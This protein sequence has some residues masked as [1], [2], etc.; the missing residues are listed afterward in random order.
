MTKSKPIIYY[1]PLSNV[2]PQEIEWFWCPFM[3][4]GSVTILEG[5]PG[6]GK[7]FLAMYLAA[8]VST[9]G[10][11]PGG[12]KVRRG[13][14]LYL[15]AEDDPAY[16]IRPRIDAMAGDAERIRIQAD[17]AALDDIGL[18][19][20]GKEVRMHRP[21]LIIIDPLYA[22]VPSGADI[23]RPNEIRAFL[24]QLTKL[25]EETGAAI[26]VIRHLRKAKG[27]KALY[28]GAG[29]I[30]VIGVAR[31]ALMVG[32]HPDDPERRVVVHHKHNLS[33]RGESLAFRLP[34][35]PDLRLPRLVWDGK[36]DL[37]ADDL[38]NGGSETTS[39]ELVKGFLKEALKRGPKAAE[40]ILQRAKAEGHASRTLDR[41]KKA[42]GVQVRKNGKIWEWALPIRER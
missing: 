42:L 27:E 16:T 30:D 37:D 19:R 41:A 34:V 15:A 11:L 25:A 24:V 29:S 35:S 6:L 31:S 9:G 26:L 33:A 32:L 22:F 12:T 8:I 4:F 3:P 18:T 20:L 39:L 10:E 38:I 1:Q 21:D 40:E 17:Y 23:Y 2:E 7:S 5:D 28:Q 36:V 14:V 13:R